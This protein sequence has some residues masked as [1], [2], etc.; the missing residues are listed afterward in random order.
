MLNSLRSHNQST[1]NGQGSVVNV[2]TGRALRRMLRG[3]SSQERAR[4]VAQ[5]IRHNVSFVD[6]SPA[7]VARLC[8]A[9]P[10]AVSIALGNAGKRG[11]RTSTLDALVRKHGADV[12]LRAVNRATA[13]SRIAAE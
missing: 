1:S 13:P 4:V 11:P 7:Q 10:G 2:L 6:L 9:N 3:K 8:E 12:L 5:L